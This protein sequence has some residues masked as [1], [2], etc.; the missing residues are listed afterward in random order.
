ML[1]LAATLAALGETS[2]A[3]EGRH[4]PTEWQARARAMCRRYAELLVQFLALTFWTRWCLGTSYQQLDLLL[5]TST[6]VFVNRHLNFLVGS[7]L[8][9]VLNPFHQ[10]TQVHSAK[11]ARQARVIFET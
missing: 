7:L 2:A 8:V 11:L 9:S 1:F 4:G 6:F 3:A 10:L 5:T